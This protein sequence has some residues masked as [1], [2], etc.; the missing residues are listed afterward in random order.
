V[1]IGIYLNSKR[2]ISEH[3]GGKKM[4]RE[5]YIKLV[6]AGVFFLLIGATGLSMGVSQTTNN[7]Q[8]LGTLEYEPKS[9]DFGSMHEAETNSTV[10][11]IWTSGGCCELTF[12]L[13]WDCPWVT[14]FPTSGVSNGEHVP[15]MVSVNTTGLDAGFHSCG[16]A[17]TTNGGG[18]GVFTVNLSV[19]Q[20]LFPYLTFYPQA[21]YFGIIPENITQST[22]F[23]I[24]NGG[25]GSLDY[26]LS[27]S[28]PWVTVTPAEGSSDG[29]HDPITV[30]VDTTGLT[31][32]M[33]YQSYVS[34]QSNGGN[35][36]FLVWFTIG[37]E[38]KIEIKT[39]AGGWFH[40][41]SVLTNTGTRDAVGVDWKITLSGNGLVIL[42]KEQAGKMTGIPVGEERTITSGLIL[43][44]GNVVV[45][46]SA[47]NSDAIPVMKK[48]TAQIL[49]TYV[50]M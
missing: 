46:V 29:E 22:T 50:K 6:G 32:D 23:D 3:I 49:F 37:T 15:I 9:Y 2:D 11:E 8:P 4:K 28:D 20:Y 18:D 26:T 38:P 33:T 16:I 35:N 42:G 24:W 25:T 41:S 36:T 5:R 34:I 27:C 47:Q 30:T 10:F 44:F 7:P 14:V 21:Y 13:T 31:P 1:T 45:T 39:I 40:V 17:I 43:G 48:S 19:I 12:N